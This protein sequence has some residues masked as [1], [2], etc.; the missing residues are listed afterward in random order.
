MNF[1]LIN[2]TLMW[3][4]KTNSEWSISPKLRP[5]KGITSAPLVEKATTAINESSFLQDLGLFKQGMA[6]YLFSSTQ[7]DTVKT[8]N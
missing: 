5:H 7:G 2:D 4:K 8:K 3:Q 6:K 1:I